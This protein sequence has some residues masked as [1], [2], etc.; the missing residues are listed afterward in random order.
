MSSGH[1]ALA[2]AFLATPAWER[3]ALLG[4]GYEVLGRR[5]R[6]LGPVVTAV[7]GAYREPPADRPRELA[8]FVAALG[9]VPFRARV[10]V[11]RAVPTR[12]VRMRWDTPR[13]DDL[14]ALAEFLE[15]D[16][17]HLDWYADRR[18]IN[19]LAAD[20]ALRHYRYTW[21]ATR[22]IEAPKP[23]LRTLQRRLLDEVLG[24][25]PVHPAAHGFV[26]G[27]DV[28][29]FTAVHLGKSTVVRLDLSAFFASMT[30][31]RVYGLF[32]GAG[33]PEPVAHTLAAL[34]T[35]RTPPDVVRD[36]PSFLLAAQLRQPHLPQGA[37]S[38]PALANLIAFRLDRRLA[39]LADRFGAD[40]SRYAD[41]LAFSGAFDAPRLVAAATDVVVD[42][43]FRV[44][45]MKTRI[46]GRADRQQLA[47][48]VVNEHAAV[49]RT[50]YD[51]LRAMLHTAARDGLAAANRAGHPDFRAYLAGRIAWV[52]RDHPSRAAKLA[53]LFTALP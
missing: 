44:H 1:A 20:G 25:I 38:S 5:P 12:V 27:R 15:V 30:V 49:P 16:G 31:S 52:G 50:E 39:G 14:A 40:Y 13:L 2:D 28:R 7:L 19:R 10:A 51:L 6:W 48:L 45:P 8:A 34:C 21:L 4:A 37:P 18:E 17:D 26:P 9:R 29:T 22:L 43:G 33:Y 53:R 23:R 35:T 32:R 47:G 11:R 46:R 3:A 41:D 36:A 24:R 42:E